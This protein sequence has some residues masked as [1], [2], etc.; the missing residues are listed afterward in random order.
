MTV[1]QD[2]CLVLPNMH[3]LIEADLDRLKPDSLNSFA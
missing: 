1:S 3:Q 2:R